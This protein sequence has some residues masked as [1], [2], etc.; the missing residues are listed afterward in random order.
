MTAC[1]LVEMCSSRMVT[2]SIAGAG[3]VYVT[4]PTSI[5]QATAAATPAERKLMQQL[6]AM[7]VRLGDGEA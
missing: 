4:S 3:M 5:A 2:N 6:E 1:A 7:K